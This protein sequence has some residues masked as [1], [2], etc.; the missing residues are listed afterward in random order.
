M[1]GATC[2]GCRRVRV[3]IRQ[4]GTG[5]RYMIRTH[6]CPGDRKPAVDLRDLPV[7]VKS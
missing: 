7:R 2:P 3:A 5:G 6:G 1:K 4:P